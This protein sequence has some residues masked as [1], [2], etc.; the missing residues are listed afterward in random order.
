MNKKILIIAISFL[1]AGLGI[2]V[3]VAYYFSLDTSKGQSLADSSKVKSVNLTS[4]KRIMN[5]N[6]MYGLFD[7]PC[8]RCSDKLFDCKCATA[9]EVT[10]YL[11]SLIRNDLSEG[12]IKDEM[13]EKY[14]IS[15]IGEEKPVGDE[16]PVP[17]YNATVDGAEL[18]PT[19]DPELVP[20][21]AREA[22]TIAKEF[23]KLLMQMPCY[24][25]CDIAWG[26]R[27]AHNSLL[28]CFIGKHGE[29][30]RI[31]VN[32]AMFAKSSMDRGMK[33]AEIR[34]VIIEKRGRMQLQL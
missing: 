5:N 27:K 34:R 19:L 16:K 4:G 18:L 24:C 32:E 12:E 33:P 8:G 26:S 15:I 2:G 10:G 7:C 1:I 30:C 25:G 31:C 17:P 11:N 6:K 23:P 22:Y 29:K 13:V 9:K 20:E 14:G 21:E 28:D 3:G